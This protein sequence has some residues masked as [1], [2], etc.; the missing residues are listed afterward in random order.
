MWEAVFKIALYPDFT[1]GFI[2]FIKEKV[3][4]AMENNDDVSGKS[5]QYEV[6]FIQ[7]SMDESNEK[8]D[9][10]DLMVMKELHKESI[11]FVE[12]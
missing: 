4:P 12:L 3:T 8:F 7:Q 11:E 5:G 9:N 10:K 6:D 2:R 1:L